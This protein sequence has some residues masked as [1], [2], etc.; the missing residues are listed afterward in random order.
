MGCMSLG[1]TPVAGGGK[2]LI[3]RRQ[4]GQMC[5]ELGL[6]DVTDGSF[7][8]SNLC[9][10]EYP[11]LGKGTKEGAEEKLSA[12]VRLKHGNAAWV[13]KE[14]SGVSYQTHHELCCSVK[15]Y[16]AVALAYR[17]SEEGLS[18]FEGRES[19]TR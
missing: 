10:C 16:R 8:V 13:L 7:A 3:A 18:A 2:V 14:W 11:E 15:G 17:C 9:S 6:V 19:E 12:A 4:G 1:L 5:K